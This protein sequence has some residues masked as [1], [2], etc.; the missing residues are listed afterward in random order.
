MTR[1]EAYHEMIENDCYRY[2]IRLYPD[3][4]NIDCRWYI[5]LEALRTMMIYEVE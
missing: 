3:C 4:K 5:A 1:E 2:C